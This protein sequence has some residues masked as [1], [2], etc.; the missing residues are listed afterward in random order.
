MKKEKKNFALKDCAVFSKLTFIKK[1]EEKF[2][3]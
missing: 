3:Q 1:K 2:N